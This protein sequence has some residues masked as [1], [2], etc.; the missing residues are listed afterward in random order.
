MTLTTDITPAPTLPTVPTGL[1][2]AG[3]WRPSSDGTTFS[4]DNPATGESLVEVASATV[5]DALA[6]VDAAVAAETELAATSPAWRAD[7]LR[8]I[9]RALLDRIE[10]FALVITLEMG[11]SLA[12]ARAEVK[13]SA[14]FFGWFA[15]EA[16]R[17]SGDFRR[18]PNGATRIIVSHRGVGPCLL[19]TPW[20]FP[21][22]MG[23]R[24]IAP[25]I[26]AGCPSI[27]KPAALTPLTS[28]LLAQTIEEIGV[29]AGA[30]NVLTTR[31]SGQVTTAI[32]D[33]GKVR[34]LSFTGS[35]AVGKH[36]L[37]QCAS[38]VMRTSMELGGNAPFIVFEDADVDEAVEGA[39]IAKLRNMGQSC[40][41][42][43]RFL[44][45]E[46]V[47]EEFIAK[48]SARMGDLTVGVGWDDATDIGPVVDDATAAKYGEL[49]AEA[50][51]SGAT[52]E[53]G[54][55][56]VEGRFVHPT[57]LSGVQPGS[58]ILSEEIFAPLAPVVTFSTEEEVL[59]LANDTE[60]GLVGFVFTHDLD[61][62]MRVI[63]R[64]KSG[65][66]GVNLGLVSNAAAPFGGV[67]ES[68]LGR[69]GGAEGLAEYLDTVYTAVKL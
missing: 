2:I 14:D 11:K 69:E 68:G 1:F 61:R 9:E 59:H 56:Q 3:N 54:G 64:L 48:L 45:A 16:L 67:K 27:L 34:K 65:M 41:A 21:L 63:D 8:R 7:V 32:I 28:L 10:E 20:N 60:Y 19:I 12:E 29:P 49:L 26:A 46:S 17:I 55:Q 38:Q 51:E 40:T 47:A 6:A 39:L 62:A 33:S 57:L 23:A 42:A 25:A 4:V 31:N 22:A 43:N 35:T 18:S 50:V 13:Y 52:I 36:L 37:K 5:D 44:V 24:K 15:D 66:I 58:R 30:V 53:V